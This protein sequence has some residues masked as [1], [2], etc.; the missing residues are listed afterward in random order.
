MKQEKIKLLE[1]FKI[2]FRWVPQ[3]AKPTVLLTRTM[4]LKTLTVNTI[5]AVV[6]IVKGVTD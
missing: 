2:L 3:T 1:I 4:S 6:K 5:K